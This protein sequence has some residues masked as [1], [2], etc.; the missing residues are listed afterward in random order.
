MKLTDFSK[1]KCKLS[2]TKW[3]M[4]LILQVS[5]SDIK[6]IGQF[7]TGEEDP[8]QIDVNSLFVLLVLTN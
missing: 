8:A 6:K 2:V 1:K 5:A 7:I 3:E 4:M